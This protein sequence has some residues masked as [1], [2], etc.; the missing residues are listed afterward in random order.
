[1]GEAR[2]SGQVE[3]E[4]EERFI[5]FALEEVTALFASGNSHCYLLISTE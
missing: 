3:R 4:S 5:S 1:M 2:N